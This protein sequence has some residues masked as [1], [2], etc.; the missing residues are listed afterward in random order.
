MRINVITVIKKHLY[1]LIVQSS[2]FL[3]LTYY[4]LKKVNQTVLKTIT[5]SPPK[6]RL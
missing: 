3:L 6:L 1:D 2:F 5:I 4:I